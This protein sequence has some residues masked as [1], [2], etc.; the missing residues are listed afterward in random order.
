[1]FFMFHSCLLL[2][3]KQRVTMVT[4]C[5]PDLLKTLKYLVIDIFINT[6]I[7]FKKL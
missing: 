1:M 2:N 6:K 5:I 3:K 7:R 4:N